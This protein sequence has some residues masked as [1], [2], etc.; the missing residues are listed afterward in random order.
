MNI[1]KRLKR[2]KK[3]QH[4]QTDRQT[5][6]DCCRSRKSTLFSKKEKGKHKMINFRKAQK[7]KPS[8]KEKKQRGKIDRKEE[9]RKEYR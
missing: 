8:I 5:G 2:L 3:A 7:C 4:R 6:N 9:R 1:S